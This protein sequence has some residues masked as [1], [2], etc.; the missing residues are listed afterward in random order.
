M[1]IFDLQFNREVGFTCQTPD[2][3]CFGS[4]GRNMVPYFGITDDPAD[5]TL[6]GYA[7]KSQPYGQVT[8]A[9]ERL[10]VTSICMLPKGL[11]RLSLACH[12]DPLVL[13]RA[14][15]SLDGMQDVPG[16]NMVF[17]EMKRARPSSI[18]A[19]AYYEAK[20]TEAAAMLLDWSLAN[21]RGAASAIRAADRSALNLTRA[22]IREHLDRAVPSSELC[23]IA[24]MSASK[25][26]RLFKQAEGMTPQEYARTLRMERCGPPAGAPASARPSHAVSLRT[27]ADQR[28]ASGTLH[29]S[30][31]F[32]SRR[33]PPQPR[34][35]R[36]CDVRSPKSMSSWRP[37]VPVLT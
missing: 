25:L 17:D 8:K 2:L 30:R 36:S 9:D 7:W 16:L 28:A 11:Q 13:S 10:D 24:C 19:P 29:V 1:A 3:F 4:Y 5:R 21:A 32:P 22:H 14:I 12:C 27:C 18:T 31:A 23:R 33:R 26:T 37:C 20:V 15:A 35:A 34:R 6:L